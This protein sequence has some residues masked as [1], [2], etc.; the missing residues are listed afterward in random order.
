MA[1]K[2]RLDEIIG[3]LDLPLLGEQGVRGK[4]RGKTEPGEPSVGITLVRVWRGQEI[5]VTEVQFGW[6]YH[7]V[8]YRSLSAIAKTITGS[9]W[10]GR[11][12]FGL[13]KRKV[14]K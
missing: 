14:R 11:L 12:F 7:G 10:N 6:E 3:D 4:V 8:V 9:H 13:T 5:R 1:A 2:H